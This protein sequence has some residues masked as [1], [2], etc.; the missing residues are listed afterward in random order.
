ML[1]ISIAVIFIAL[2]NLIALYIFGGPHVHKMD[3]HLWTTFKFTCICIPGVYVLNLL[4]FSGAQIFFKQGHS[5]IMV[6]ALNTFIYF[7]LTVI[8][9]KIYHK[10][11]LSFRKICGLVLLFGGALATTVN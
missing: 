10:E 8:I 6:T 5:L 3:P 9:A 1:E 2:A 11:K 4:F 7:L